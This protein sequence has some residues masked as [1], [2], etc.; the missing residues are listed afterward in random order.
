MT[1]GWMGTAAALS[2]VF[3]LVAFVLASGLR[4]GMKGSVVTGLLMRVVGSGV[5]LVIIMSVYGGIADAMRYFRD[6]AAYAGRMMQGDFAMFT[7]PGGWA[8]GEWWGTQFVV[9]TTSFVSLVL[10]PSLLGSF[11]VYALLGFLGLCGFTV[12]FAQAYPHVPPERYLLWL[13]L[14]PSLWVWPSVI[15]KEALIL[16][17]LGVVVYAYVRT[18]GISWML[19]GAG[20][21]LI[22]AV[23]PQVA[24]VV[25][26]S[27]VLGQWLSRDQRWTAVRVLQTLGILVAG[28]GIIYYGLGILGVSELGVAGVEEYLQSEAGAMDVGNSAVDATGV[29]VASIP[30]ALVNVLFRPFPWEAA[31]A[32]ALASSLELWALW[33]VVLLRRRRVLAALRA[34]R[35]SRLL[36]M[37]IPFVLIYASI[38][39]MLVVNMGIIA[40]QRIFIFPFLLVLLEAVPAGAAA[41]GRRPARRAV[42]AVPAPPLPALR[43]EGARP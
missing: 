42:R 20:L 21:L 11:L 9:F 36:A 27:V 35:S 4:P 19:L 17:G 18:R 25:G 14:F 39:G 3:V 28:L 41:R 16:L 22:F 40:R 8:G 2:A 30:L 1:Q 7:D 38:F 13:A 43:Q 31:N 33:T 32:M 37:G 15:G 34:W 24:A 23:R 5:M 12:A 29:G 26:F 6:G 10:G